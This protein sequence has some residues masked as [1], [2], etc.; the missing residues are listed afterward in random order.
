MSTLSNAPAVQRPC[1]ARANSLAVGE[2]FVLRDLPNEDYHSLPILSKSPAW[3]FHRHGPRWFQQTRITRTQPAYGSQAMQDGSLVHLALEV[4]P[5]VYRAKRTVIPEEYQTATGGMSQSKSAKAWRADQ[6]PDA[7]LVSPASD[8]LV[9]AILAEAFTNPAFVALYERVA[10]RELSVFGRRPDGHL[11]RCR[12]DAITEDGIA[13]DYKT[14]RDAR[15]LET[16]IKAVIDHGY[17]FQQS[18]Y[19][20]LGI[21]AGVVSD[22]PLHFITLSTTAPYQVQVVTLPAALVDPQ[23]ALITRVLDEIAARTETDYWSPDG[24]GE[25]REL[26]VPAWALRQLEESING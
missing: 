18:W 19:Q 21:L 11:S 20:T 12:Y 14:T 2:A 6:P 1:T 26:A 22:E 4:T 5:P 17:H 7:L 10:E 9:E 23:D 25:V 13:L 15:P 24:Y 3:D 16:W 8:A